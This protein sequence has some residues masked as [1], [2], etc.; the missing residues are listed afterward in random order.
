[1]VPD[2]SRKRYTT[3]FPIVPASGGPASR[4]CGV[5][6]P[7]RMRLVEERALRVIGRIDPSFGFRLLHEPIADGRRRIWRR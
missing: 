1:M 2:R 6:G 4:R 7:L 3:G 5:P